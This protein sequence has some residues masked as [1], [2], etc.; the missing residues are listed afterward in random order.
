MSRGH[1][2]QGYFPVLTVGAVLT[3]LLTTLPIII[4]SLPVILA[5][6]FAV[7]GAARA[8]TRTV[9][10]TSIVVT[11][12]AVR[13]TVAT[14]VIAVSAVGIPFV[15]IIS[16]RG[17]VTTTAAARGWGATTA[18]RSAIT[19][20]IA[21]SV[22][23]SVAGSITARARVKAPRS[24]WR[25]ACPLNLQQIIAADT[26]VVHLMVSIIGIAAAL[27]FNESEKTAGGSARGR[28]ITA[29]K[30]PITSSKIS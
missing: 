29:N 13:I 23:T 10:I 15:P 30:A 18:R 2:V 25:S 5:I 16:A 24:R 21:A 17:I 19:A 28:D 22:A 14:V 9:A 26:L 11:V 8:I 7:I 1:W 3:V 6:T 27:V 4:T 12:T 20:T